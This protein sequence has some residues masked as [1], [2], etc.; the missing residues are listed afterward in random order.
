MK[1]LFGTD[2]IR[3]IAL[4]TLTTDLAY[5]VGR[6]IPSLYDASVDKIKVVIGHDTRVSSALL[7]SALVTGLLESGADVIKV[8]K[9][10]TAG[11]AYLSKVLHAN[12]GVMITASHNKKEYNGIK[13]FNGN[14]FKLTKSQELHLE[15]LINTQEFICVTQE[16]LGQI[17]ECKKAIACYENY[18]IKSS[19]G[20]FDGL[21]VAV[22]CANGAGGKVFPWVLKKLGAR[23]KIIH[24]GNDGLK[25]NFNCGATQTKGLCETV[26]KY[27]FQ[28]GFAL[29]GD[30]DRLVI[31]DETGEEIKGEIIFYLFCKYLKENKLLKNNIVVSTIMSN[32]ALKEALN[33]I[34]ISLITTSVGDENVVKAMLE[35][36]SSF[37]GET[38]GHYLFD[39]VVTT[40]DGILTSIMFLNLF[41]TLK[42][43]LS[44]YKNIFS[45]YPQKTINI[46]VN[47]EEKENVLKLESVK[48]KLL[49]CENLIGKKGRVLLRASGTEDV[50]RLLVEGKDEQIIKTVIN[51]MEKEL[52]SHITI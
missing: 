30:A 43:P 14:G 47:K 41:K 42:K 24:S 22:D 48:N 2:G 10:P 6:S 8:N 9:M 35:N 20:F 11:V 32:T 13:I 36:N 4:H 46:A 28:L 25:I 37:G 29:D 38:S 34:K 39:K 7:E 45:L 44:Y 52:K 23:V 40:S 19:D 16:K 33:K 5:K 50:L 17:L 12:A 21:S 15:R 31:V 18:L 27:N 26:K 1:M 3:G 49:E 51:L